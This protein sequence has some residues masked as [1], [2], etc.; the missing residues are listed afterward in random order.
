[1]PDEEDEEGGVFWVGSQEN[2]KIYRFRLSLKSG[3]ETAEFLGTM[4]AP[5]TENED[6]SSLEYDW[7]AQRV[8]AMF[9]APRLLRVLAT[10]GTLL[11]E[12]KDVPGVDVEAV[13][14]DGATMG[15]MLGEDVSS[16][17]KLFAPVVFHACDT[18]INATVDR[19]LSTAAGVI[20]FHGLRPM[21]RVV[22]VPPNRPPALRITRFS[23]G[24]TPTLVQT[25][26]GL[27]VHTASCGRSPATTT[28]A[29]TSTPTASAPETTASVS[30]CEVLQPAPEVSQALDAN[31]SSVRVHGAQPRV[32]VLRVAPNRPRTIRLSA[33]SAAPAVVIDGSRV[34]VFTDKC[35]PPA[36]PRQ[37]VLAPGGSYQLSF[38]AARPGPRWRDCMAVCG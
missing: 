9:D 21:V 11:E 32:R 5:W 23:A 20:S 34:H 36:A 2:C 17:V 6:L 13:V 22:R 12:W 30:S 38:G 19:D 24:A 15:L 37:P 18:A 1:V 4:S 26:T 27:Q 28:P 35:P 25:E 33:Y 16:D 3:G 31:A 29:L 14:Y 10:D 8:L 7:R